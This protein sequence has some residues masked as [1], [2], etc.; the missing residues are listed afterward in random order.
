[1]VFKYE[2]EF[3]AEENLS[4]MKK[5]IVSHYDESQKIIRIL[6]KIKKNKNDSSQKRNK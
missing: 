2:W 4:P 3:R 1:M 5:K 6:H